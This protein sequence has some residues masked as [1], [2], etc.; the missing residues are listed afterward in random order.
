MSMYVSMCTSL[1]LTNRNP[2]SSPDTQG[3]GGRGAK[4]RISS[5]N[6]LSLS[7][8]KLPQDAGD[9]VSETEN[10]KISRSLFVRNK[11]YTTPANSNLNA[12]TSPCWNGKLD[13][14]LEN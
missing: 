7:S 3:E 6:K 13:R 9:G 5:G 11:I 10:S 14:T 8:G 1:T 12:D 2:Y 4:I